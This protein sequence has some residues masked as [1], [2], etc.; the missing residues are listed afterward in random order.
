M[1]SSFS[2]TQMKIWFRPLCRNFLTML[3]QHAISWLHNML[4][5]RSKHPG[6]NLDQNVACSKKNL[7]IWLFMTCILMHPWSLSKSRNLSQKEI[8]LNIPRFAGKDLIISWPPKWA[9]M[10]APCTSLPRYTSLM[11]RGC[12][13]MMTP[14]KHSTPAKGIWKAFYQKFLIKRRV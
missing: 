6:C 11:L 9:E 13:R 1:E 3:W 14:W 5:Q 4:D 12:Q 8:F 7:T 2:I 10:Y